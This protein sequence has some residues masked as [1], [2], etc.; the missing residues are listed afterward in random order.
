MS[1]MSSPM[2]SRIQPPQSKK[3]IAI[4]IAVIAT[5]ALLLASIAISD[6]AFKQQLLSYAG[7]ESK[8]AFY[9]ADSGLECALFHDLKV[10]NFFPVPPS[11]VSTAG[12][13]VCDGQSI[14]ADVDVTSMVRTRFSY[15]ITTGGANICS[16]VDVEKSL[17]P[18][19]GFVDTRIISRGYNNLCDTDAHTVNSGG[20]NVERAL[21][22]S[23]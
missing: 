23:Y 13:L 15:N 21:E 18:V 19:S 4:L 8:T 17:N 7:R 1:L 5:S 16:I 9:A 2:L 6:I 3:G 20:R 11:G 22:V 10:P 12:P 14:V